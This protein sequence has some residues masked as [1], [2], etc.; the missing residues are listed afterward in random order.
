MNMKNAYRI[1][2]FGAFDI[3]SMGDS[4]FPKALAFG[5]NKYCEYKLDLFSANP[6]LESYNDNGRVCALDQFSA[7]NTIEK[8]DAIVV[9]G[10]EFL[11]FNEI[12]LGSIKYQPGYLWK[13]PIR[14]AKEYHIKTI[15]NC[16]GVSND[17]TEAQARQLQDCIGT[18]EYW[19]VRDKYSQ[20]RLES[21][22]I[23]ADCIADNLWYLNQMYP[24]TQQDAVRQKLQEKFMVDLTTPYIVVQYG[25]TKDVK[26]LTE[27]L[28]EI[29]A[30]TGYRI[31]L[32]AVNYCHEDRT[33]MQLLAQAGEGK[34]ETLDMHLQPPEMIAVISGACAFLGTSLHGNLT[35]ASYGVPF[36]GIDMYPNFVSK[37][38]GIFSMLGC[39]NYLVPQ[40]AGLAA[41]YFDREKDMMTALR[42]S[43]KIQEMQQR[44]DEHFA[45]IAEIIKEA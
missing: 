23:N 30:V 29:K 22:G 36:V 44:L 45:K 21:V 8:Y 33:G 20:K 35:A 28:K 16:V 38:D 19:S 14:L 32:M 5:L 43:E 17:F 3:E 26:R 41:A 42:I 12:T 9:G 13:E 1:A 2:Q 6:C 39:E 24:K 25:T 27:Q 34:F 11:S 37:M 10:G 40:E 4:L 18:V 31:C 15:I 7:L